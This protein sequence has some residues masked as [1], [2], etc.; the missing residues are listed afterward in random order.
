MPTFTGGPGNNVIRGTNSADVIYGLGGNDSLYGYGGN[1]DIYGGNGNDYL[2]GGAGSD[3]L[4]G[5]YGNDVLVGG[6][7]VD[8]LVGGPGADLFI[9]DPQDYIL[10][11]AASTPTIDDYNVSEGDKFQ[12]VSSGSSTDQFSYNNST[13]ALSFQGV[14]VATLGNK[15]TDFSTSSLGLTTTSDLTT[16]FGSDIF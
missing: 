16:T 3:Y 7:G 8:Y 15:P 14:Q 6:S 10:G 2:Y 9:I 5:G 11:F 1:D 13:G 4:N 12:L